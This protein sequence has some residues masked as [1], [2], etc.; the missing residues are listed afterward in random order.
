MLEVGDNLTVGDVD[1]DR[2]LLFDDYGNKYVLP[3]RDAQGEGEE[4]ETDE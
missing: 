3:L 1:S 2:M 4:I